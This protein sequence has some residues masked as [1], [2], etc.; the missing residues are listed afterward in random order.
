LNIWI[1]MLIDTHAHVNFKGFEEDAEEVIQ[2]ALDAGVTVVNIG[3]QLDTS[4]EGIEMANKFEE[5]VYA[6]IGIHPVHTYSQDL[7]EEETQ[8]KTREEK[9]NYEVYKKLGMN[10]KV[11]GIGECGLDYFRLPEGGNHLS[12]K[13]MQKE[14][15]I[16]QLRLA[17]ELDKALVIHSR[18]SKGTDDACLDILDILKSEILNLKSPLR[19]VLH[20]YTGSPE[21]A[22]MF[23]DLGAYISFN[24]IITFDKTGNQEAVLKVVP[25]DKILLETDCPFLTPVPMRGKRNEPAY[26][27]YVAQKVAECRG[28]T[29]KEMEQITVENSKVFYR[30]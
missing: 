3:T 29:I 7:Q 26:V 17:A 27:Q 14:S 16:G 19:F 5:G 12:I 9:F 22:K 8:F 21:V 15:F 23:V 30:I 13:Q 25:N 6:V 24:G 18:S 28:A 4:K 1:S 2:R 20:S 11:V 10:P